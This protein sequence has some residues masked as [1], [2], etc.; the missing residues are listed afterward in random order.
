MVAAAATVMALQHLISRRINP[1]H[2]AVL[3]V[4]ALQAG[5]V[6]NA[7]PETAELD[8]HAASLR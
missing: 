1:M 7:I 5:S 3:T 4:G 6:S 8:G 2:P